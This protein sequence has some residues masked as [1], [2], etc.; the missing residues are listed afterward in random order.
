M[1]SNYIK[2]I[3]IVFVAILIIFAIY[4]INVDENKKDGNQNNIVQA[5]EKTVATD[6]RLAIVNYD[7]I[8]PVLSNNSNVQDIS[9]LVFEPLVT[10]NK[11]YKLEPCLATEWSMSGDASY[12]IKLRND[13]KWQDGSNF[14]AKDVQFTIDTLKSMVSIY[15]YNVQHVIQVDLI[16]DY[17]IRITLDQ[18]NSNFEYKLTFPILSNNFYLEQD[19]QTTE[20][21]N[22][23]MGTGMYKITSNEGGVITLKKNQNWWN[24]E[25][26]DQKIEE[27]KVNLYSSMGDAYNAFKMGNLDLLTTKSNELEKYVGTIGYNKVEYKGREYDFLAMNCTS[28]L[29]NSVNVRKAID[30]SI[31]REN[32]V[33]T[34]YNGKYYTADFPLDFGIWLYNSENSSSGYNP[35]QAK[36]VLINDGWEYKKGY[37]QKTENYR[38]SKLSLTLTVNSDNSQRVQVAEIIKNNLEAVRNKSKNF[39]CFKFYI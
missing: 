34:V 35:D 17:T 12:I 18:K 39:K 23:P 24:K 1:K 2:Y 10:M 13:V 25:N 38:T 19:F 16:D 30:Y 26:K 22:V 15:S 6:L 31:D 33:A 7:S 4:K 28:N 37:W 8:N 32:I 27:I 21:N 5:E 11:E 20:K 3:F 9:R 36:Q 29:L 14:T